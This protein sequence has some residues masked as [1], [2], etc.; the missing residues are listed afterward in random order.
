QGCAV[1][2]ELQRQTGAIRRE[3][4]IGRMAERQNAGEAKQEVDR[5]GG[6]REH[7]HPGAERRIAAE[8]R[9]P[10]GRGHEKHPDCHKRRRPARI[11][12]LSGH[13]IMPSSPNRPRG[14]ISST[15]AI[16]MY[17][18]ASLA[19]G[20]YTA[21]TPD[22]TPISNPPQRVPARLPTP[23]T[24]MAT[25]LGVS[26]P[27]P[28]VGSRPSWPAASTPLRPARKMP[29]AKL[30]DRSSRT[31]I[32]IAATVSRSRVPARMRIPSRV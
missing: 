25:K 14:R 15:I 16:M 29:I 30:R 13:V 7:K 12:I 31:L 21:V 23:P 4:E 11:K 27:V 32:P 9:H 22:A 24:I 20:K 19:E 5:H 18:T 8:G 2:Y 28:M 6:K 26:R 10:I 1:R 17:M 3:A